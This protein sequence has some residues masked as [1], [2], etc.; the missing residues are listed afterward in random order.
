MDWFSGLNQKREKVFCELDGFFQRVVDEHLNPGRT[1]PQQEDIIDVLLKII[2]EQSGFGAA[3]L[4]EKNIKAVLLV[5][6]K[7]LK[8][9]SPH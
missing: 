1:K 2:K 6:I 3:M 5:I 9:F 4:T 7:A 8:L